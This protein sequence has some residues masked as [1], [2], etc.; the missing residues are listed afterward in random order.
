MERC[1]LCCE[2]DLRRFTALR[3]GHCWNARRRFPRRLR[4]REPL[5][6]S[7]L[8]PGS[9]VRALVI[10]HSSSNSLRHLQQRYFPATGREMLLWNRRQYRL[11]TLANKRRRTGVSTGARVRGNAVSEV[12]M[13]W[14]HRPGRQGTQGDRI[15]ALAIPLAFVQASR[16]RRVC[17][18]FQDE[19]SPVRTPIGTQVIL[20][21]LRFYVV[22][23]GLRRFPD[24]LVHGNTVQQAEIVQHLA[25]AQHH[26]E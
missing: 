3:L 24:G 10:Y 12:L 16:Q 2:G 22:S 19:N 7:P 4:T 25:S 11:P 18:S 26:R 9:L 17:A 15:S 21:E 20:L 23:L 14:L 8:L 6:S 1:S 5:L 13:L